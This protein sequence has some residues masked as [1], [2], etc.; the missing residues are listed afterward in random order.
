MYLNVYMQPRMNN[1]TENK[2]QNV[3]CKNK[4]AHVVEVTWHKSHQ[5][6][7]N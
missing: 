4:Q 6:H 2:K 1:E 3:C 7:G 5:H